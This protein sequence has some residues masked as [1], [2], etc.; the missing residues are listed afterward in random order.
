M[1]QLARL[2]LP[3]VATAHVLSAGVANAQQA[4]DTRPVE[5]EEVRETMFAP[6]VEIVGTIYSRH[7][8]KLTAGVNGRLDWVAEPGSF[9][10]KGEAVAKIDP[11]PLTL[12]QAEQQAE[13]KRA[14]INLK[15]L[16]R[17]LARLQELR[18]TNSAS[19]FQLDQTQ[20]QYDL[21][22]AD[23]EIA[24][25]R[26]KQIE[27]QLSRTTVKAPFTGVITE[28][29][30]EAG[31]DVNRSEILAHM[32]DTENLEGRVFVPV[33]YLSYIRGAKTITVMNDMATVEATIKA[34]VPAADTRSQS[35]ELRVSLPASVNS[36]WAAGQM[37]RAS[38]P[39]SSPAP[40]LTVHRDA[41]ILRREATYVVVIDEENKAHRKAVTVGE[42]MD[43]RISIR[44]GDIKAGDKVATRGAERLRDGQSVTISGQSV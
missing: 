44:G 9:L 11:L 27:D 24:Q 34:I 3:L 29:L 32:L 4:L 37:I 23:L 10:S 6:T 7:N 38:L 39:V 41:L 2:I 19:A 30:R 43:E 8:V 35:F 40:A 36:L 15:Y 20:S 26:L 1:K 21:A 18:Q 12:Q 42:G 14:H 16:K 25:L 5:V 17:E 31:A 22:Q 33:K 13:I 28:R